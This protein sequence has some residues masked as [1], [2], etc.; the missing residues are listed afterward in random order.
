MNDDL[1]PF[2]QRL[3]RQSVKP[4]PA[5][6]RAQILAAAEPTPPAPR[7]SWRAVIQSRLSALLWPY[8]KAWAGLAGVWVI[9]LCL[10]ISTGDH[11]PSPGARTSLPPDA[12]VQLQQQQKLYAELLGATAPHEAVPAPDLS[13]KPRSTRNPVSRV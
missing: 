13:L 9:I 3:R 5:E 1:D 11:S 6:W 7:A 12:L 4:L 8:P 10:N 2:E